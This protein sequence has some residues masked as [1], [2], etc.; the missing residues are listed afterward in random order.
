MLDPII[1][2]F[3]PQPNQIATQSYNVNNLDKS[4]FA[5]TLAQAISNTSKGQ[6]LANK[7]ND[8]FIPHDTNL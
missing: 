5:M 2:V 7:K 4:L 1:R 8:E 6:Q 3:K